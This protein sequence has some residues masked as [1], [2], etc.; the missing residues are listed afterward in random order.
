MKASLG[1]VRDLPRSRFGVDV[2]NDFTP[3]YITIRGKGP[4]LQE[5]RTAA[6]KADRVLLATDLI[7]K[8]GKRSL[9]TWLTP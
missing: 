6:K 9:G 4:V 7:G 3:R 2:E 8:G 5:L 1:H